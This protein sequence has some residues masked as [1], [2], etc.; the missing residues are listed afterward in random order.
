MN[1]PVAN[2]DLLLRSMEPTLNPGVFVFVSVSD[3]GVLHSVDVFA[4]V[5]EHEGLSAVLRESDA[6]ALG[7]PILFR[8]S[9]ITLAIQ[10]D[11]QAVGLTA[12]FSSVLGTAGISCN[13][14]AG[15]WHDHIFVPVSRADEA[16]ALLR[17]L[18]Q[19]K[20]DCED[21]PVVKDTYRC[22]LTSTLRRDGCFAVAQANQHGYDVNQDEVI[23]FLRNEGRRR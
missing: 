17:Q 12:A 5:R 8:A 15:A 6:S 2:L 16:M 9:W 14:V 4:T 18:Q 21:E 10:S 23:N 11:L 19:C 22:S 20:T 7:L 13:V 3:P 1:A